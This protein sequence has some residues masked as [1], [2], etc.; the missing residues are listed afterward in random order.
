[1]FK[2][3][4]FLGI[5]SGVLAGIA[6]IIFEQIYLKAFYL[7]FSPIAGPVSLMSACIFGCVLAAIGYWAFTSWLKNKGE[8]LFNLLFTIL[9][10][11]SI[12]GPIAT[13]LPLDL[14]ADLTLM[15]PGFAITMH[16]FPALA[17]FTL[18]PIF[19]PSK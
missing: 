15:F 2:K 17:W 1:M 5:S 14:D 6:S 10:F 3:S 7:D 8:I 11:A 13:T 16:F 12:L 4:L 9:S 19:F 18:K